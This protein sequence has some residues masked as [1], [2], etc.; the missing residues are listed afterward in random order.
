[1]DVDT[2]KASNQLNFHS[3]PIQNEPCHD[4]THE[5]SRQQV[6]Y[7]SEQKVANVSEDLIGTYYK[8]R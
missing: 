1:M 3:G 2:I 6:A 7:I 8:Y 5:G 4:V